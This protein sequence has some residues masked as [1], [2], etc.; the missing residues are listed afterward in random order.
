MGTFRRQ[1]LIVSA[2]HAVT[3]D[4]LKRRKVYELSNW[5]NSTATDV[6]SPSPANRS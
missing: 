5:S 2:Q 4:K 3:F 6:C 1:T